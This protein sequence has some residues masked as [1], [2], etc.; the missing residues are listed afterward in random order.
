[1][2]VVRNIRR[3]PESNKH[4]K[5]WSSLDF[6]NPPKI[7][8]WE[9]LSNRQH[10]ACSWV[11]PPLI[12][13]WVLFYLS[14]KYLYDFRGSLWQ[15]FISFL[16]ISDEISKKKA[17]SLKS[18]LYVTTESFLKFFDEA[19]HNQSIFEFRLRRNVQNRHSYI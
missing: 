11:S 3:K 10:Q 12:S 14:K 17:Q 5:L 6:R 16:K 18:Y 13:L 19:K 8:F 1:M 9:F 7:G 2:G 15:S 4:G